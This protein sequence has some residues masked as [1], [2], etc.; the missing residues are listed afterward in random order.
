[1]S[2]VIEMQM[3]GYKIKVRGNGEITYLYECMKCGLQFDIRRSV[4]DLSPVKCKCGS[5]NTFVVINTCRFKLK[6]SFPSK[7][8]RVDGEINKQNEIMRE[9]WRSETEIDDAKHALRE[10]DERWVKNGTKVLP[11]TEYRK[12]KV[13][14]EVMKAAAKR[15]RSM[16]K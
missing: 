6:G 5:D 14:K 9:G 8:F 1:M 2:A 4:M 12:E 11:N 7:D 10:R 16:M 15:Q 3:D 13:G